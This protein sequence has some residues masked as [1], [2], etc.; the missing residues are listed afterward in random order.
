MVK[1]ITI[2]IDDELVKKLRD[3][4]AKQ[5]KESSRSVSFSNVLNQVVEKGL[6][7]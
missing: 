6:K 5:I 3:M 4:Q 1:R 7:K 2:M